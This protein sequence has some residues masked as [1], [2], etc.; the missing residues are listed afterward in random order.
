MKTGIVVFMKSLKKKVVDTVERNRSEIVDF[1]KELIRIP[2]VTE[3]GDPEKEIQETIADRLEEA[4]YIID[5]WEPD[6]RQLRKHQA[7]TP[8]SRN[9]KNR[10]IVVGVL[11]GYEN[12]R[13]IILNGHVDVV[14]PDPL[15][16]W[17]ND[18][19]R[20]TLSGDKIIGRGS[21]DMKGGMVAMIMAV[22]SIMNSG[23]ELDGNV[24]IESVL[25]EEIG[26]T[27]T[28]ACVLRG[29]KADGAVI[30]EP[31]DLEL[32]LAHRGGRFFKISIKGKSAHVGFKHEGVSALEKGVKI[33]KML[34][35]F[36][37]H[38]EKGSTHFLFERYASRAPICVGT[39]K[40]GEWPCTVPE[41][42]TIEGTIECLPGEDILEVS[43]D[44]KRHIDKVV[45]KDGWL[46]EHKPTVEWPSLC[47]ESSE[48]DQDAPLALSMRESYEEITGKT[49][50]YGGFPG[51]CD[52]RLLTRYANTPTVIFGPG[53]LRQAHAIDEFL[54]V[55]DL[56]RSVKIFALFLLKWCGC[57][58]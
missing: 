4:G 39:M 31:T 37:K 54:S 30:A 49:I 28:L 9:F 40:S 5:I 58:S 10:P 2:S 16:H 33:L 8:V 3:S 27:G 52:M 36:E 46:R 44:L 19:W 29:Y 34:K 20:V 14:S 1:L 22:E 43:N 18:P 15:K 56:V 38:R 41:D 6:L 48:I 53:S 45:R 42:A 13:S 26:G 25:N 11:R 24:I 7:Y 35:D 21:S 51:G 32:H 23:I 55:K 47:I 57:A 50:A 12:G 17:K